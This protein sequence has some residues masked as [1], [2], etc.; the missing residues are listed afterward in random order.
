MRSAL[1]S[2]AFRGVRTCLVLPA[3]N[4]SWVVTAA[5][6]SYYYDLLEAGVRIFEYPHGLL[7]SKSLTIDGEIAIIGS[8]DLDRRSFDL[9]YENNIL[10][11]SR[12]LTSALRERQMSYVS[13]SSELTG[14]DIAEWSM[15]RR[16]WNNSIAMLGPVI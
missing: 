2:A 8:A 12:S 11:K 3:K 14:S 6:R 4:D 15:G 16:L 13:A 1:C 9:N 10:L 7:H 5:S